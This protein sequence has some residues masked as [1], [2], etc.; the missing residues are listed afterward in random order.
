M[1]RG[2]PP[3]L[4]HQPGRLSGGTA[5]AAGHIVGQAAAAEVDPKRPLSN[6][7][8]MPGLYRRHFAVLTG[9]VRLSAPAAEAHEI[10]RAL[11]KR[12]SGSSRVAP[13]LPI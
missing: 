2:R 1:A 8:Q 11:L 13:P 10:V 5:E 4:E 3:S 6:H 9:R 7:A 12:S